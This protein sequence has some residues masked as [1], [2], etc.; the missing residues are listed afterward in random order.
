MSSFETVIILNTTTD[1]EKRKQII[2]N[3]TRFI[4]DN[5]SISEIEELGERQL[6]YEVKKQKIGYYVVIRFTAKKQVSTLLEKVF[7]KTDEIL[8]FVIVRLEEK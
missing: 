7:K 8:K 5:G 1:L 3:T 4:N 6:A 2:D